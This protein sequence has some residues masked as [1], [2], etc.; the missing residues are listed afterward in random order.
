MLM[1]MG[2]MGLPEGQRVDR[3]EVVEL[4]VRCLVQFQNHSV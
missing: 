4:G 1:E 3:W 2:V